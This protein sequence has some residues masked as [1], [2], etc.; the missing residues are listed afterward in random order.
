MMGTA[1]LFLGLNEILKDLEN[2]SKAQ[3]VLLTSPTESAQDS[4]MT[5]VPDADSADKGIVNI[6]CVK[7]ASA[8]K[9]KKSSLK[10]DITKGES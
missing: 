8:R 2:I 9:R 3:Q 6:V 4:D 1:F 5:P 10:N 7:Q